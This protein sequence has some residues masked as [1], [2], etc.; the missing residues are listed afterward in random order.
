MARSDCQFACRRVESIARRWQGLA[1]PE[2]DRNCGCE[3][4]GDSR[5][6][7]PGTAYGLLVDQII[8]VPRECCTSLRR[9]VP[10]AVCVLR[11]GFVPAH[12]DSLVGIQTVKVEFLAHHVNSVCRVEFLQELAHNQTAKRENASGVYLARF[13]IL[14]RSFITPTPVPVV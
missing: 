11:E 3:V 13:L 12:F 4:S 9:W 1:R 6:Y 10:I 2:Q 14:P 7:R 5:P 8:S